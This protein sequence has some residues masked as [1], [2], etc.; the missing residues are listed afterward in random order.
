[1]KNVKKRAGVSGRFHD[2]RHTLTTELAESGAGDQTI[3]YIAGHVSRQMLARYCH[4][5]MEAKRRALEAV[6]MT[7]VPAETAVQAE[8]VVE[9]GHK[10]GHDPPFVSQTTVCK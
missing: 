8:V 6:E 10:T 2:S 9:Q 7:E 3:I 1:V 4:I 5:R